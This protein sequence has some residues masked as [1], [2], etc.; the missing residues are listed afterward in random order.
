MVKK[1]K[2]K[3]LYFFL[4]RPFLSLDIFA[5]YEFMKKNWKEMQLKKKPK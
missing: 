4:S 1:E 2:F 3:I 5:N